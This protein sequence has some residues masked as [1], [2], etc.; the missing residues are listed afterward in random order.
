MNKWCAGND[1]SIDVLYDLRLSPT[2]LAHVDTSSLQG[3]VLKK[4]KKI[5]LASWWMEVESVNGLL[6][7]WKGI[8][9]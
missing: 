2:L 1:V 8:S 3:L 6:G 7:F 5:S 4:K 9:Q